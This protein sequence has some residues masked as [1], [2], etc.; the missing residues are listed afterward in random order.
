M[1]TLRPPRAGA[2]ASLAL[3]FGLAASSPAL[4][5]RDLFP[6]EPPGSGCLQTE[7]G[8]H[9]VDFPLKHTKVDADVSGPVARVLVTQTFQNPYDET[10]EAVYVFPLP[11]D[12]AVCD[13]EMRIGER[14]IRGD[15]ER[16]DE[17]RRRYEEARSQGHVASLLEQQR[18][19]V[20][21]QSVANILPGNE[22]DV[23]ITYV[24]TLPYEKGAW[25]LVFPT[26]VG[27]RFNPLGAPVEA[28]TASDAFRRPPEPDPS[29]LENPRSCPRARAPAMTSRSL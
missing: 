17:A 22:I 26:V 6:D 15:I 1:T 7:V 9:I 19:N 23:T 14:T 2:Q 13:F 12:A 11:H 27:P 25:E 8:G 4:A 3:A 18:P 24:E 20:F 28:V 21:T 16:R 10:I 29:R 5:D